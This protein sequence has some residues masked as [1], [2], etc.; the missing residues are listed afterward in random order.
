MSEVHGVNTVYSQGYVWN[1]D[2]EHNDLKSGFLNS[3]IIDPQ[4]V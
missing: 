2:E 1:Y 4:K 3:T